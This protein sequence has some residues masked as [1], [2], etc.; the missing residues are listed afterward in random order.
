MVGHQLCI[1]VTVS[2]KCLLIFFFQG[3]CVAEFVLRQRSFSGLA[4]RPCGDCSPQ[5][6]CL[7]VRLPGLRQVRDA[8]AAPPASMSAAP[9]PLQSAVAPDVPGRQAEQNETACEDR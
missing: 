6:A 3:F 8:M 9:S 4:A 7:P 5:R 1:K 2:N